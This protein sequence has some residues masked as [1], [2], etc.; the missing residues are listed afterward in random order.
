MET[1]ENLETDLLTFSGRPFVATPD[2]VG[3]LV[4]SAALLGDAAAL[5]A[6]YET[7]GYL[8]IRRFHD[9]E[10]V[11]A[12]RRELLLKYATVGEIDDRHPLMDA[13]EG[14]RVFDYTTQN[15]FVS[16][17]N[18]IERPNFGQRT[19]QLRNSGY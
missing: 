9:P 13:I 5:R 11:L 18:A 10:L 15:P 3:E 6:R 12:T 4:D 17:K 2:T 19:L 8:Y 16:I 1:V 14:D 7:D